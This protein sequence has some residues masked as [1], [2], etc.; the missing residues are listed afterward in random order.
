MKILFLNVYYDTFLQSHYRDNPHLLN[1]PYQEQ[2]DSIQ[3]EMFGDSDCYSHGMELN[4]WQAWDIVTNCEYLQRA[5]CEEVDTEYSG[6]EDTVIKQ[7]LF[8]EP[9]VVYTQGIWVINQRVHDAIRATV[10]V[11]TGHVGSA[12]ENFYTDRFDIIFTSIP[13]Y[14]LEFNKVGVESHY[15]A[16]A[17]DPRALN[18]PMPEPSVDYPVTFVGQVSGAHKRRRDLLEFLSDYIEI[19]CWGT[20][21]EQLARKD[22]IH[23]RGE[24][25]GPDMF[26]ILRSSYITLNRKIDHAEPWVGNMRMFEATGCGALLFNDTGMNL[27]DLFEDN[28]LVVYEDDQ[29]CL[30]KIDYYL[31]HRYEGLEIAANGNIRTMKDHTYEKRMKYVGEI[32]EAKL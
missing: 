29:D 27:P 23:Y 6:S 21:F 30:E 19:Y 24:A 5:W 10:K 1:K 15:L 31:D 11:I 8:Y 9:D 12:L 2:L 17:F 7:I 4:G 25:W 18:F 20:G 13:R 26:G 14:A 28:E 22:N 3:G 32:L 16:L